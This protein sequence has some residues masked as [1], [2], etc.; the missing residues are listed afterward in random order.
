MSQGCRFEALAR[1]NSN[2]RVNAL[3]LRT[4]H[5]K[6]LGANIGQFAKGGNDNGIRLPVAIELPRRLEELKKL[7]HRFHLAGF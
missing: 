3:R 4:I 2:M 6:Q 5:Q 1:C 7:L